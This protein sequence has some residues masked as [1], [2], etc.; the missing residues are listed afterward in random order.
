MK[1][2]FAQDIS[3]YDFIKDIS[4][5]EECIDK[6]PNAI[7]YA[8][9]LTNDPSYW[10]N[11]PRKTDTQDKNFRI[12]EGRVIQGTLNW[13]ESTSKGTMKGREEPITLKR[14]YKLNWRDYSN[15]GVKNGIFKYLLVKVWK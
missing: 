8:I 5:L 2:Q 6:L 13:K 10:K 14:S 3:R 4:R 9:F 7:G 1:D 12:H 15:L 11:L